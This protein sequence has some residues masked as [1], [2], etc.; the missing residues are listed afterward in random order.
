MFKMRGVFFRLSAGVLLVC[1]IAWPQNL[2]GV[3][4]IVTD[5][6]GAVIPNVS[7]TLKN[8]ATQAVRTGSSDDQG[9]YNFPQVQPGMYQILGKAQGFTD[10]LVNDVKLLINSPLKVNVVFEKV[11]AVAEVISVSAEAVQLNTTDASIGNA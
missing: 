2:G 10:V 3:S 7:L 9:R 1:S 4:G 8:I 11:G 5:P 6:T